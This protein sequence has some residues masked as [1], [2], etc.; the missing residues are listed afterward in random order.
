MGNGGGGDRQAGLPCS[1]V[2]MKSLLVLGAVFPALGEDLDAGRTCLGVDVNLAIFAI[3]LGLDAH[4]AIAAHGDTILQAT[5]FQPALPPDFDAQLRSEDGVEGRRW[6]CWRQREKGG[7]FLCPLQD[8]NSSG[9][10]ISDLDD[11]R[12]QGMAAAIDKMGIKDEGAE[13]FQNQPGEPLCV[14]GAELTIDGF[15]AAT[16]VVAEAGAGTGTA[17]SGRAPLDGGGYLVKDG[18][19]LLKGEAVGWSRGWVWLASQTSAWPRR[20]ARRTRSK[21]TCGGDEDA[22]DAFG[23]VQAGG[24]PLVGSQL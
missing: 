17:D 11:G 21:G 7:L 23:E 22:L 13:F 6:R 18:I 24:G 1:K 2:P 3:N 20:A 4:A 16:M 19:N 15:Q 12:K 9:E 5:S 10:V 14:S 8:F